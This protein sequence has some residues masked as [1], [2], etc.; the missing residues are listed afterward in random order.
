MCDIRQ[1]HDPKEYP[2]VIVSNISTIA[3]RMTTP[4]PDGADD[5]L[6]RQG[7]KHLHHAGHCPS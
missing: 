2:E 3:D 4:G 7:L 5:L 6:D 1:D